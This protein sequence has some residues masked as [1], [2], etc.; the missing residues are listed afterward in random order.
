MGFYGDLFLT[1]GVMGE[2]ATIAPETIAVADGLAI[3]LLRTAVERGDG[4]LATE[5]RGYPRFVPTRNAK[6]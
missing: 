6:V 3:A 4:R 2:E 1:P 5:A